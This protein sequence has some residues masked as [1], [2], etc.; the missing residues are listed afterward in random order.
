MEPDVSD[1]EGVAPHLGDQLDIPP[2]EPA[3]DPTDVADEAASDPADDPADDALGGTGG[4]GAGG[5][6]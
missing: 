5:A 3:D 2:T 1:I 4:V 6:G